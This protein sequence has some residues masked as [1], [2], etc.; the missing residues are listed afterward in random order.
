M[1]QVL[2]W[3]DKEHENVLFDTK[4]EDISCQ[5]MNLTSQSLLTSPLTIVF[6]NGVGNPLYK[7]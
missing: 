6:V 4:E 1:L 2:G 7:N 5:T 3:L